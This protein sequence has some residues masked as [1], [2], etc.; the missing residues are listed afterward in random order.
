MKSGLFQMLSFLGIE[1][2]RV[3]N[4]A[5]V[6]LFSGGRMCT[7]IQGVLLIAL[8]HNNS[9]IYQRPMTYNLSSYL[10]CSTFY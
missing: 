5:I 2:Q 6:Q 10:L 7:K 9:T 8:A 1:G 4:S 3:L